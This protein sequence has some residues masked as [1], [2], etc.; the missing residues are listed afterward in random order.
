[1]LTEKKK[2]AKNG[3]WAL[4]AVD[5]RGGA[6]EGQWSGPREG[7]LVVS[8]S[9]EMRWVPRGRRGTGGGAA[10]GKKVGLLLG[11]QNETWWLFKNKKN[12][13]MKPNGKKKLSTT[14]R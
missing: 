2:L 12:E 1:M 9:D 4:E 6:R 10:G 14:G 11:F 3:R 13:K 8:A 5:A 7:L